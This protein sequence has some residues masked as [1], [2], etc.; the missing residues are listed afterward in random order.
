MSRRRALEVVGVNSVEQIVDFSDFAQ[1]FE[2]QGAF[3]VF[4]VHGGLCEGDVA[5]IACER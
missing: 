4:G 3:E 2:H 1:S 5:T